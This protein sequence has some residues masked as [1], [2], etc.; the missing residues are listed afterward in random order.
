MGETIRA[1]VRGGV[2]ESLEPLD[3]A[4]G[5]EATRAITP[6]PSLR[7]LVDLGGGL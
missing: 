4:E 6:V 1:H 3:L 5:E 7:R 2:L